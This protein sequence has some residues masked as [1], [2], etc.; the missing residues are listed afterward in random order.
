[1]NCAA[2]A[3]HFCGP[4]PGFRTPNRLDYNIGAAYASRQTSHGLNRVLHR[5]QVYDVMSDHSPGSFVLSFALHHGD[6]V[7]AHGLGYVDEHQTN[8]PAAN[9]GHGVADLY[10]A[11]MQ[12]A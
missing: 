1:I 6:Y 3:H 12:P 10:S 7:T 5:A 2:L 4:H 9:H 11:L 8:R